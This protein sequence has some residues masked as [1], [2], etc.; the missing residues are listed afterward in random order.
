MKTNNIP[1]NKVWQQL[2][3]IE[4][5]FIA[6]HA[7]L[8]IA[9]GNN[10]LPF[11]F[12]I[13]GIFIASSCIS[14]KK[15]FPR[16]RQ[17]CY[18]LSMLSIIIIGNLADVSLNLLVYSYIAKS[19]FLLGKKITIYIAIFT[20]IAWSISEYY[21]G[22][23]ELGWVDRFRYEP[24]FGVG[25]FNPLTI[26]IFS[27]GIYTA[28]S[29]LIISFCDKIVSEQKSRLQVELQKTQIAELSKKLE[30]NRIARDIHDLLGHNLTDLDIL[31]QL[32]E[33]RRKNAPEEADRAISKA[34]VISTRCIEDISQSIHVIKEERFDLDCALDNLIGQLRSDRI[35]IQWKIDLPP[36]NLLISN[37]IYFVVKE[38]LFNIKKH[39]Q[40][41]KV[42]LRLYFTGSQIILELEDNGVGFNPDQTVNLGF[43]LQGMRERIQGIGGIM[44]V[45][46]T[47]RKGTKIIATIPLPS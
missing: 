45:N 40:A 24:P 29:I 3:Y 7:I 26:L 15:L 9:D 32:A 22:I 14:A 25:D 23:Q 42:F 17:I 27:L 2:C 1:I 34:K 6:V 19:F 44:D 41:S 8:A 47:P 46:T 30:R 4:W 5:L 33:K 20:G 21:A 13:Y 38:A 18:I 28:M 35:Q 43:G 36:L 16:T 11:S 37:E 39:A 12:A 31:L 10:Q